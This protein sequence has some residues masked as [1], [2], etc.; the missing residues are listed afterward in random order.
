MPITTHSLTF[1]LVLLA[2]GAVAQDRDTDGDS[3][4]DFQERHKYFTDPAKADSDGDGTPDGDWL[5]RREFTYTVRAVVLVMK[6]VTAEHL[7]DDYQDARVLD[8]AGNHVELE[9]IHYPF[10]TVA[11]AIEGNRA[12]RQEAG[13]MKEWLDPGPT[14]DWTPGMRKELLAALKKDGIDVA[15]LDDKEAV[16]R[17]SKWLL[18]RAEYH[19]GFSSFITAF[20]EKGRPF[21]PEELRDAADRGRAEKNLTLQEQWKREISARGMF[22]TRSR[23]SCTSSAIYLNGCLR[24]VGIPTRTVLCIP[25]VDAS[26]EREVK[27]VSERLIHNEVRR[28][29][30]EALTPGWTSHTFNEVWVGGR[31]RR[32]NYS[33]LGQN[34]LDEKCLGLMTHIAT[35]RDWA[36]AKMPETV[37]RRQGLG[38]QGDVFGGSNPYSTI[39]LRDGFGRHSKVAN[40]PVRGETLKVVRLLW[41]DAEELP[42]GIRENCRQKS[43]FGLIAHVKDPGSPERLKQFLAR[44]DLRVLV[45]AA[46]HPTLKVGFDAGCWWFENDVVWIYIP[47][48]PADRRDLKP[49][50]SYRVRSP[51]SKEGFTWDLDQ[52]VTRG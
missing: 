5:E 31:W 18:E 38:V 40:P 20:D 25:L 32:L 19:D 3:L 1:C 11:D 51:N 12:W 21:V 23:G 46:G 14:S 44:A 2:P 16:E 28:I 49:A 52:R 47:F 34:I 4:S 7:N 36:D 39:S 45:E 50:V 17:V 43:R 9:V 35:F 24:A 22:E 27:M 8:D 15:Q 37:G 33:R 13:R 48:G 42:E 41:T 30:A 29:A 10:N 6:P 26:D